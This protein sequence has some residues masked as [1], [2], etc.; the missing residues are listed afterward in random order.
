MNPLSALDMNPRIATKF[1]K[2]EARSLGQSACLS[3]QRPN[4]WPWSLPA[5]QRRSV[6]ISRI[7]MCNFDS[8]GAQPFR[9]HHCF[10]SQHASDSSL[11]CL[12]KAEFRR[13]HLAHVFK[14]LPRSCASAPRWD[15][16]LAQVG[17]DVSLFP[18]KRAGVEQNFVQNIPHTFQI[19]PF[20]CGESHTPKLRTV[21]SD[22]DWW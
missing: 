11:R 9:H 8:D 12:L 10:L 2:M 13:C 6:F 1:T 4:H 3:Q 22:S 7:V 21:T 15:M 16:S 14:A 5:A 19:N 20:I 18:R 17:K